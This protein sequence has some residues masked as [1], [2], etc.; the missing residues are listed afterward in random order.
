MKAFLVKWFL[1]HGISSFLTKIKRQFQREKPEQI[2]DRKI[3]HAED[4]KLFREAVVG[5]KSYGEY[6]VGDSTLYVDEHEP[7]PVKSAETDVI[8]AEKIANITSGNVQ[9]AHIDLGDVGP[10]GRPTGYSRASKFTEYFGAP[11]S[12][13]FVPDVVL[14][15]GRF[16]VA[17]FLTALLS[18]RPGTIIIFDDYVPRPQYHVVESIVQPAE[19]H[20]R[21]AKF[22]RPT[23]IETSKAQNLLEKFMYVMD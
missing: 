22:V 16:R 17:C 5:C 10:W 14:V 4:W 18:S 6:G 7:C 3:D 9:I 12:N 20:G 19:T 15:D 8:W 1:P 2:R 21:Q 23:R 11:F 13:G